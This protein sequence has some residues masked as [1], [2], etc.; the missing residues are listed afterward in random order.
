MSSENEEFS[1]SRNGTTLTPNH[2]TLTPRTT[3]IVALACT[4]IA[5]S[6]L[7]VLADS[8]HITA[9]GQGVATPTV[10]APTV[11]STPTVA[12]LGFQYYNDRT[13]GFTIQYPNG[14]I[15]SPLNPGMQFA[16]DSNETGYAMQVALPGSTTIA[17]PPTD[18]AN[19]SAW[20]EYEMSYLQ[21]KYPQNFVRLSDGQT[22]RTIGGVVW[23]GGAGLIT[24][25]NAGIRVQVFA[26]VY[27][28]HPYIINLL[29]VADRF[30]AGMIEFFSPMLNNFVF[31][32]STQ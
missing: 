15:A 4:L 31:L 25:N 17:N 22:S 2:R 26:T 32:P 1:A 27:H 5:S 8:G 13:D 10:L 30:S 9:E 11:T 19:P 14:W 20:V 23:Q 21:N 16:D 18:A 28:G 29:S 24:N 7:F 12:S 6:L 3:F